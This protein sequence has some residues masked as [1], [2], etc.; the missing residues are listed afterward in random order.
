MLKETGDIDAL[1]WQL[2]CKWFETFATDLPMAGIIHV[3]TGVSKSQSRIVS[4]GRDGEGSIPVEYLAALDAQ[5]TKW[6]EST[7]LPVLRVSTEQD[8]SVE[9]CVEEIKAFIEGMVAAKE[10][11]GKGVRKFTSSHSAAAAGG[12]PLKQ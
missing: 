8:G 9:G 12:S 7:P 5:H 11:E 4:R 6:V 1:E 2:Y 10:G 3:T